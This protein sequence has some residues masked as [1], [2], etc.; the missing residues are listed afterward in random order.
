MKRSGDQ[1][2]IVTIDEASPHLS[3]VKAL[4]RES[5]KTLGFFPNGAFDDYAKQ[6]NILVAVDSE[7]RC[8]GYLLYR[9]SRGRITIV[10]LCVDG[11]WRGIG[12]ARKLVEYLKGS[13]REFLGIGLRCRRD[14]KASKMWPKLGFVA[15]HDKAGKSKDGSEL[16]F[17][18]LDYGHPTLFSQALGQK[19]ESKLCIA[20]DANVFFDFYDN[21]PQSE[22]SRALLAD[23]LQ[24]DLEVCLNDEIL[25]EIDRQPSPD[26]R[27]K[28]RTLAQSYEF[29]PCPNDKFESIRKSIRKFFPQDMT[30]SDESDLRQLSRTIGSGADFFVSRDGDL[31]NMADAI[32][33]SYGLSIVRPSDL[34]VQLDELRRET[35]YRPARLAGSLLRVELVKSGQEAILTQNFQSS[36]QGE[37]KGHFQEHLRRHLADPERYSCHVVQNAESRLMALVAYDRTKD[38][39]L[40]VPIFRVAHGPLGA[41]LARYL[42]Q[43]SLA[44]SS[45]ESRMITRITDPFPRRVVTS[46]LQEYGFLKGDHGWLRINLKFAGT[47]SQLSIRLTEI[48]S[49]FPEVSDFCNEVSGTLGRQDAVENVKIMSDLERALWPAKIVDA[50]IPTY[51]VPIKPDWAQH[52]FDEE[53]ASQTL[54]GAKTELALKCEGVYYRARRP[55]GG[56]RSPGRILWYVSQD[57]AYLGSGSIRACSRLEEARVDF[58]KVLFRKYRRMGI[59]GWHDVFELAKGNIQNQIMAL[60]FGNTEL[61]TA[62][63]SWKKLQKILAD[64]GVKT[65]IQCPICIPKNSFLRLYMAGTQVE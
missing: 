43:R 12:V 44:I 36:R 56:L 20:I 40:K 53:L 4:W 62:P 2:K 35:E 39:K 61:F 41:T 51:I 25:N 65:Q 32:Y 22:E 42:I 57:K 10:H 48:G 16:T 64:D 38:D 27:R 46:A 6:R 31:L 14:F 19:L 24:D 15:Q 3:S 59:Y 1:I 11:R 33:E 5:S 63:I 7:N 18:W 9:C 26:E 50:D 60:L 17:W 29:L 49:G 45:S 28:K 30:P 21:T 47:A 8:I 55:S 52:L 23:W 58:P 54:F 37:T 13:T 34:V